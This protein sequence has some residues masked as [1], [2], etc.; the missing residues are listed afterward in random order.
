MS[1]VISNCRPI[2]PTQ[3]DDEIAALALQLEEISQLSDTNK[4]KHA[5]DAP[6]DSYVA[7]QAFQEEIRGYLNFLHDV[8]IVHSIARAVDEDSEVI[9]ELTRE[10]QQVIGDRRLASELSGTAGEL[11]EDPPYTRADIQ[12][13]AG[14]FDLD[15]LYTTISDDESEA[16]PSTSYAERQRAALTRLPLS[17]S[18]CAA[19][20]DGFRTNEVVRL[21][22]GHIYCDDCIKGLFIRATT[23]SGLF[24]PRCCRTPISVDIVSEKLSEQ[25]LIAFTNSQTEFSTSNRTYCNDST[26]NTFIPPSQIEGDDAR[27]E[28]CDSVTCSICKNAG[29]DG[30][31]PEDTALQTTLVLA[32]EMGWQRCR[33]CGAMLELSTGCFHMT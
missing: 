4:G 17:Y 28:K 15:D 8:K 25:E 12:S 2:H 33:T 29:H 22:C 19:C 11:E 24:P 1:S 14:R 18:K 31:C 27:C 3:W 13:S 20:M 30:D 6:P 16:G 26:C 21:Q 10:D 5:V 32:N 23:D 9:E 7:F